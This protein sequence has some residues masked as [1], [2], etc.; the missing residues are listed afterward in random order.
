MKR[1]KGLQ[2]GKALLLA[3]PY[4]PV[5]DGIDIRSPHTLQRGN[6]SI[7]GR[8]SVIVINKTGSFTHVYV[9]SRERYLPLVLHGLD[10]SSHARVEEITHLMPVTM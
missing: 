7:R 8:T 3:P 6:M 9:S 2:A 10:D 4:R 5:Y 1:T